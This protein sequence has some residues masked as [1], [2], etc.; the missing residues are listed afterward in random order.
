MISVDFPMVLFSQPLNKVLSLSAARMAEQTFY[1]D[2]W[3][4]QRMTLEYL[5]KISVR[6]FFIGGPIVIF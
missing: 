3:P 6:I 5:F 2:N 4:D 1:Q